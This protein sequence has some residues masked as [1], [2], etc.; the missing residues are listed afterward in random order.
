M[1]KKEERKKRFILAHLA[2]T[3]RASRF[4]RLML[5]PHQKLIQL[6]KIGKK[7]ISQRKWQEWLLHR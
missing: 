1:Q 4:A 3:E 2:G 6:K 5:N 7:K